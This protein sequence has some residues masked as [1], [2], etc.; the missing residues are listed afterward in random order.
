MESLSCDMEESTERSAA[1]IDGVG[2]GSILYLPSK[3]QVTAR[4]ESRTGGT[5]DGLTTFRTMR[6][7]WPRY[8]A[9]QNNGHPV[10]VLSRSELDR[11]RVFIHTVRISLVQI[12]SY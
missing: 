3:A 9:N 10:V 2:S 8:M 5:G 6:Q 12:D 1:E 7:G 4:Y 11:N